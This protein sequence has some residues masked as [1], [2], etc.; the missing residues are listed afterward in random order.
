MTQEGELRGER[1]GRFKDLRQAVVSWLTEKEEQTEAFEPVAV[2]ANLLADQ[3]QQINV[4]Y[5][6]QS[7]KL[8]S[9]DR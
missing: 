1:S 2:S 7:L 9:D 3:I 4:G 6:E 8:A 5:F